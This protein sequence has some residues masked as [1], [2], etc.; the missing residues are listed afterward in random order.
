[1]FPN[2]SP[3]PSFSLYLPT[4]AGKTRW[5]AFSS[6]GRLCGTGTFSNSTFQQLEFQAGVGIYHVRLI[7]EFGAPVVIPAIVSGN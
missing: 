1:L 6:D 2:P 3:G 4:K 7:P 5:E